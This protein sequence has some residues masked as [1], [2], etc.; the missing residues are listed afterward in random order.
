MVELNEL[1]KLVK[2]VMP[3]WEVIPHLSFVVALNRNIK[4]EGFL[5]EI[6]SV[7]K[8]FQVFSSVKITG[9]V[10]YEVGKEI[11]SKENLV[12]YLKTLNKLGSEDIEETKGELNQTLK[13]KFESTFING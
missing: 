11:E 12:Q 7:G 1:C 3:N 6:N 5:I 8:I 10:L 2:E 13:N 4:G 9:D